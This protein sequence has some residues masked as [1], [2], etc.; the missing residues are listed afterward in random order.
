MAADLQGGKFNRRK[1]GSYS[2]WVDH[3]GKA[4]RRYNSISMLNLLAIFESYSASSLFSF[5]RAFSNS[6]R[7]HI[8]HDQLCFRSRWLKHYNA[9]ILERIHIVH[10]HCC[11]KGAP[12]SCIAVLSDIQHLNLRFHFHLAQHHLLHDLC[13]LLLGS[14]PDFFSISFVG[15]DSSHTIIKGQLRFA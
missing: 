5:K 12:V 13:S 1:G 7:R 3:S 8:I 4:S 10:S 11:Y 6:P 9:H 2:I 15:N 14:D